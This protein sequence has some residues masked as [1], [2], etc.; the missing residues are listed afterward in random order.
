MSSESDKDSANGPN[1]AGWVY[2]LG[3]NSVGYQFCHA[4]YLVIEGK[5]ARIYKRDPSDHPEQKPIRQGVVG[6]YLMVEDIGR[7]IYH[8]RVRLFKLLKVK[9]FE[10]AMPSFVMKYTRNIGI[11]L[12]SLKLVRV[13]LECLGIQES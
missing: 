9:T 4:R 7:Q 11:M 5:Y 10:I 1:Y 13:I 2:H 12:P 3:S 8:G 6:Q